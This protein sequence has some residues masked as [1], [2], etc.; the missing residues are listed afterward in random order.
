MTNE[1]G[2][3]QRKNIKILTIHAL[4]PIANLAG[5]AAVFI[6]VFG[7]YNPEL[8]ALPFVVCLAHKIICTHI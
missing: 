2:K 3:I 8:E 6:I 7:I 4:L 1:S 5:C